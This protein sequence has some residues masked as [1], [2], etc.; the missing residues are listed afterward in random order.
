MA[1][2][3]SGGSAI[4]GDSTPSIA[5]YAAASWAKTTYCTG[6]SLAATNPTGPSWLEMRNPVTCSACPPTSDLVVDS[7][8]GAGGT[9]VDTHVLSAGFTPDGSTLYYV[10]N[11]QEPDPTTNE[12]VRAPTAT[13]SATTT[14]VSCDLASVLDVSPDGKVFALASTWNLPG[15][16]DGD[17][18]IAS[19]TVPDAHP[20][21]YQSR[22]IAF[23]ADSKQ[24]LFWSSQAIQLWAD[25][26]AGGT[27]TLFATGSVAGAGAF[28]LTGGRVLFYSD[29]SLY[30]WDSSTTN[31][32]ALLG[33][34]PSVPYS[35]SVS[36][37]KQFFVFVRRLPSQPDA[38]YAVPI[39]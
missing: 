21:A 5:G 13:P 24:V 30:E 9:Y 28:T 37:T 34:L 32:P 38:I 2:G 19:T 17:L 7:L 23:T 36:A 10:R 25:P 29:S 27:P 6:C 26:V 39:P 33:N 16:Q 20:A 14:L 8:T 22:F 1:G 4:I 35:S 3:F 12:L 11:R 31:P 18:W 15:L